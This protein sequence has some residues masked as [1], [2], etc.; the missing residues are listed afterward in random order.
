LFGDEW[1]AVEVLGVDSET[2]ENAKCV[3]KGQREGKKYD[4]PV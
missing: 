3:D 1:V 4:R 2:N